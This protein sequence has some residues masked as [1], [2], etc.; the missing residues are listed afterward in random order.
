MP[1]LGFPEEW[2]HPHRAF[3]HRLLVARPLVV[4]MDALQILGIEGTVEQPAGLAGGTGRL[5]RAHVAG[6]GI[7]AV[8]SH[9]LGVLSRK[10]WQRLPFRY[11]GTRRAHGRT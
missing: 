8:D 10:A 1:L 4:G 2:F 11:S 5:D 3:P 9:A 7:G 6:G